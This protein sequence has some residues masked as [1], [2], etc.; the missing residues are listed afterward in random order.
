MLPTFPWLKSAHRKF[1]GFGVEVVCGICAL[2]P[3]INFK[4]KNLPNLSNGEKGRER[5]RERR[6]R[7]S[8]MSWDKSCHTETRKKMK[9]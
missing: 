9:T 1:N 8:I 4:L 5:Q 6:L 2:T 3:L 7:E